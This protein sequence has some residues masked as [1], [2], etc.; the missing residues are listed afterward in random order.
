MDCGRSSST[1][2]LPSVRKAVA[3]G[4]PLNRAAE[5]IYTRTPAVIAHFIARRGT[6]TTCT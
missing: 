3:G 2:R 4:E 5:Y 1:S 6:I